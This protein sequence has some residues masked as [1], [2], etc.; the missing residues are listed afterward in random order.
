MHFSKK[1]EE[2]TSAGKFCYFPIFLSFF[3]ILYIVC[4]LSIG[5]SQRNRTFDETVMSCRFYHWAKAP[6]IWRWWWESNPC[7]VSC[8]ARFQHAL[9]TSW[10]HQHFLFFLF[11]YIIS[12]S[13][14]SEITV[15]QSERMAL[16]MVEPVG[17]E[18]TAFRMRRGR[19]PNWAKA[20][21]WIFSDFQ[22]VQ[23]FRKLYYMVRKAGFEPAIPC[24]RGTCDNQ[25]SLLSE[26]RGLTDSNSH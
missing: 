14:R 17:L 19:S 9:F 12:A 1:T 16:Q 2:R 7:A 18:P 4:I 5:G 22:E 15:L 11:F 25:A 10:V 21:S 26:W 13:L 3:V 6:D 23:N 24:A 20:P 8:L